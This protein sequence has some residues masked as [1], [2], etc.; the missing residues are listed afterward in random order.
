[1]ILG[2]TYRRR[3]QRRSCEGSSSCL[4]HRHPCQGRWAPLW[5]LSRRSGDRRGSLSVV[6]Q[7]AGTTDCCRPQAASFRWH[8]WSHSCCSTG[9]LYDG[10][11][12]RFIVTK[13][14]AGVARDLYCRVLA[15]RIVYASQLTNFGAIYATG[16]WILWFVCIFVRAAAGDDF[17]CSANCCIFNVTLLP[18]CHEQI[19]GA[20]Q[21]AR[22]K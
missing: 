20:Q 22:E 16:L 19:L 14:K 17:Q 15:K 1:M 12:D 10:G 8:C 11:R 6:V 3:Y 4:Q 9:R 21:A 13:S 18:T 2:S 7:T 5:T